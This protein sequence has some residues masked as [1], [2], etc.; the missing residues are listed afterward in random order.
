[1]QAQRSERRQARGHHV[2]TTLSAALLAAPGALAQLPTAPARRPPEA[3]PR[4]AALAFSAHLGMCRLTGFWVL[5][6]AVTLAAVSFDFRGNRNAQTAETYLAGGRG[7]ES[8]QPTLFVPFLQRE[9]HVSLQNFAMKPLRGKN[10]I[11]S[12]RNAVYL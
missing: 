4:P 3:P 9:T 7:E 12:H 1:M 8:G 5:L 6:R 2:L 11:E 10:E